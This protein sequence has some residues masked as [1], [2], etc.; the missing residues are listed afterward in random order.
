VITLGDVSMIYI[1]DD[2]TGNYSPT[3]RK[4]EIE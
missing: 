1:T 2:D 4:I 3:T